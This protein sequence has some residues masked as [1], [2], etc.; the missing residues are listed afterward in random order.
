MHTV[1]AALDFD[2]E[3]YAVPGP[4][5]QPASE[6]C[7][8]LLRDGAGVVA[9]VAEFVQTLTGRQAVQEPEWLQTLY[10]GATLDHTARLRGGSVVDLM[11]RLSEMELEGRVVR[12]PGGRY[13]PN[14][15][16]GDHVL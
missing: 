11:R 1:R 14:G 8:A 9:N 16:R 6:G 5:G 15:R 2:R 3:V 12:L 13:G 4:V 10:S 7:L